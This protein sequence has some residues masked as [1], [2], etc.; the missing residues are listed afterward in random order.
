MP[1]PATQR[2]SFT[3]SPDR[4][5][6]P[7]SALAAASPGDRPGGGQ[8]VW[9]ELARLRLPAEH[10]HHPDELT[11]AGE[12][13][14]QQ[15]DCRSGN[16]DRAAWGALFYHY[17]G[18]NRAALYALG[19]DGIP[20]HTFRRRRRH[21]CEL[22]AARLLQLEV[23]GGNTSPMPGLV[24]RYPAVGRPLPPRQPHAVQASPDGHFDRPDLAMRLRDTHPPEDPI[25]PR[26]R[27]LGLLA[28]AIIAVAAVSRLPSPALGPGLASPTSP[29]KIAVVGPVTV[30]PARPH[31][32]DTVTVSFQVRNSYTQPHTLAHLRAG[33]RGP[34]ACVQFWAAPNVDF[35][36]VANLHLAPGELFSYRASRV[37]ST[38]GDYFVGKRSPGCQSRAAAIGLR[39]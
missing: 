22:L 4:P 29:N 10:A 25:A 14:L 28:L 34:R 27:L 37:L 39:V 19:K 26:S 7:W 36:D 16:D 3:V 1:L 15:Q 33:G 11:E 5:A 24:D 38:P 9:D 35:P 31:A 8:S 6:L 18:V 20:Y 21:G 32:G 23:R 30:H 12:L 2:Y 13:R 17:L